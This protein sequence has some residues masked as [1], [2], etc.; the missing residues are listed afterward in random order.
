M[1]TTHIPSPCCTS[2]LML[3]GGP[4]RDLPEPLDHAAHLGAGG[5]D[6]GQSLSVPSGAQENSKATRGRLEPRRGFE[7]LFNRHAL[8]SEDAFFE[9]K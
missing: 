5:S 6:R 3:S 7:R 1:K 4:S 2:K 8:G 9:A